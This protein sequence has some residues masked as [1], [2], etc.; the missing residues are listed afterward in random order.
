VGFKAVA[1]GQNQIVALKNYG[2]VV[3]W[4]WNGYG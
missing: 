3:T 4:G 1:A 2:T